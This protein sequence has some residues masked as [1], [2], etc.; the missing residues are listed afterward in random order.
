MQVSV[1]APNKLER[2]VTVIVPVE[3]FES[4]FDKRIN[5][6]SKTIKVNGFRTGKVPVNYVKERYGDNARQEALTEVIQSSLT[7]AIQ[8]EKLNPVEVPRVEP[9]SILPGQPL[10]FVATFEIM[11][12]V[13]ALDFKMTS[14][15]KQTAIISDTDIDTVLNHLL[16]QNTTWRVVDRA[17][18]DKD[19]VVLDFR[20]SMDGKTF[21]GG[22]AHDYPIIIGSKSMI[23]GFEEGLIGI[24]AGEERIISV[25]FPDNYF[26]KD[27]S[28]KAAEFTINATKISEPV[29]PELNDAFVKKLG[30]KSGNV[31]DLRNEI[32]KNLERELERVVKAKLK[33]QVFDHLLENNTFEIPKSLIT[34]EAKRIHEQLHP[35]HAGEEHGH[36]DAEMTQFNEAAKRNVLLGLFVG[37]L[38]RKHQMTLDKPRLEKHIAQLSSL[39]RNP[40]EIAKW[41]NTNKQ[42]RAEVEMQVL[43]DQVVEKLLENVQLTEKLLSYNDLIK[44]QPM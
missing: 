29:V 44:T 7:A 2:R 1:E 17:A 11:P 16:T 21:E 24:K 23:P 5:T 15:E 41:Y 20:G 32:H 26:A 37:Y 13:D 30:V 39:Y 4:V 38:I 10:E 33:K 19:Q 28:G 43:E 18:L 9:K 27:F 35:H 8:Q 3:T 14:I 42:A 34:R 36:T 40:L 12:E 31:E 6:L 22:E 25:T